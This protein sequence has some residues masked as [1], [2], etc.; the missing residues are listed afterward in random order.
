M[1]LSLMTN[2]LLENKLGV[3]ATSR[4]WRTITTLATM[5]AVLSTG[6]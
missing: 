1:R 3:P 4:N 5:S 2:N 6:G